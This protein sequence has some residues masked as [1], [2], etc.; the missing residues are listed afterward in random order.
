[1][2]FDTYN[3]FRREIMLPLFQY[4]EAT[5]AYKLLPV[6][7]ANEIV[8]EVATNSKPVGAASVF[9]CVFTDFEL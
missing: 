2:K 7:L 9:D 4:Q 3:T 5:F 8:P 1:M 6:S